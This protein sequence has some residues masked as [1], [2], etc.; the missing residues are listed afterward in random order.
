MGPIVHNP[1]RSAADVEKLRVVDGEEA[2]PYVME[3]IRLLTKEL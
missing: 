2:T 3:T 1:I